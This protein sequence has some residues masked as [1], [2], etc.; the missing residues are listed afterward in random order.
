MEQIDLLLNSLIKADAL[1]VRVHLAEQVRN[2]VEA[3]LKPA[4]PEQP[5]SQEVTES[6]AA[7]S[8]KPEAE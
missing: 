6:I 5:A 3:L 7:S 4:A 8:V 1:G 2:A